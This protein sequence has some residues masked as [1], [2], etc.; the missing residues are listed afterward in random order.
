MHPVSQVKITRLNHWRK[1]QDV[2]LDFFVVVCD[3]P[4]HP[5][6]ITNMLYF[7][8]RRA[9]KQPQHGRVAGR[10]LSTVTI[11]VNGDVVAGMVN[12]DGETWHVR[13]RGTGVVEIRKSEGTL[14][15]DAGSDAPFA[16]Q[17]LTKVVAPDPA[18]AKAAAT[19]AD[20]RWDGG[21]A[22]IRA[23]IDLAVAVTN[24]AYRVSGVRQRVNL[25]GA[26]QVDYRESRTHGEK[27]LF[28]QSE[29][30][31][32][33]RDASDGYMDDALVLRDSYAADIVYLI[34][35]QPGGGGRGN[36][37][38]LEDPNPAASAFAISNSLGDY[39]GFFA[40]ELGHV[41]GL[42]HDRYVDPY[43][44]PYP[45]S[46]GYVN[47]KAFADAASEEK[48]WFTIMAYNSQCSDA[49]FGW[50]RE[51]MRFSNPNQRYP[52]AN[53]DPLGV[54]GD[55]P[56]DAVDGPADAVR[57]LNNTRSI[58]A[59]FRPSSM[60]CAYGLSRTEHAVA[61][62]GGSFSIRVSAETMVL[63]GMETG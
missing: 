37:L 58:V 56:S 5:V 44:K 41:M 16:G 11:V 62:G 17:P 20:G 13:S 38:S 32:R 18:G 50:C 63:M 47:Q 59:N 3:F 33:L 43:N 4:F 23:N 31:G 30:L 60:R 40:H 21:F 14:R 61:A 53:G 28:N 51:I 52:D 57:S 24:E 25:V 8:N 7:V 54:P 9:R 42:R 27:G 35:D 26:V 34:V 15:C 48:R 6:N 22:Q 29:D 12:S 2:L 46:H 10:P 49:D 36:I 1:A 39:I 55:E 19:Q 45:Y